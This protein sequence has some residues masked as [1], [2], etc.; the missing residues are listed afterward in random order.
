MVIRDRPAVDDQRAFI[1]ER[2][3]LFGIAARDRARAAHAGVAYRERSSRG[4]GKDAA[5]K[6]RGVL[7]AVE[8]IAVQI[9]RD[10]LAADQKPQ[11]TALGGQALAERYGITALRVADRGLQ[12]RPACDGHRPKSTRRYVAR[13]KQLFAGLHDICRRIARADLPCKEM[14]PS[15]RGKAVFGKG[16]C[17]VSID[18]CRI[19]RAGAAAVVKADCVIGFPYRRHGRIGVDQHGIARLFNDR[20]SVADLDRPADKGFFG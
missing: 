10:R 2:A 16:I 18:R 9:E 4:D 14:F 12:L 5:E 7:G 13:Y 3:A 6:R 8:R 19:H 20:I 17:I 15:R 11:I 1:I